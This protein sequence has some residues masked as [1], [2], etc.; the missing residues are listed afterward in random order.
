MHV[1]DDRYNGFYVAAAYLDIGYRD[2]LFIENLEARQRAIA[3]AKQFIV[4][5]NKDFAHTEITP[6]QNTP[7]QQQQGVQHQQGAQQQSSSQQQQTSTTP[8]QPQQPA[9]SQQQATPQQQTSTTQQQQQQ[10]QI[11]NNAQR[12]VTNVNFGNRKSHLI[13]SGFIMR[14][15]TTAGLASLLLLQ[16]YLRVLKLK[17]QFT[18]I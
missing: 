16:Y 15:K 5:I 18:T 8:Q 1:L 11:S 2:M 17:C 13:K 12:S 9:A 14:I 7:P 4:N 6:Q 3:A 10:V